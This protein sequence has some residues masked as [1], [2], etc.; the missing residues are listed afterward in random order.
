MNRTSPGR[1][2]CPFYINDNKNW[3]KCDQDEPRDGTL[4][5]LTLHFETPKEKERWQRRY[6][7]CNGWKE[8]PYADIAWYNYNEKDPS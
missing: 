6:C 3:L 1:T 2:Q 7:W 8:C 4:M 5:H